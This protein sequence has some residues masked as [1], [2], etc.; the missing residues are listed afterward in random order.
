M[1]TYRFTARIEAGDGGGAFVYFPY[2]AEKEFETTGRVPVKATLDGVPYT[3]SLIKYGNPVLML[4]VLKAIRQQIGKEPGDIVDVELQRDGTER[5]LQVPVDLAKL[6]KK[7]K[8]LAIFEKLSYTHRGE[9][10]RWIA[11][12]KR[13]VTR[14]RRLEK[15]ADMLRS[16]MKTPD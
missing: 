11:D 12:A 10:C 14:A 1:K 3:G 2:D 15:V 7:E 8:V 13:E 6:L 16:G 5:V 4:P 9:Y